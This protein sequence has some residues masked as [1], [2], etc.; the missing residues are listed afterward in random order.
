[1]K[2]YKYICLSLIVVLLASCADFFEPSSP[3][4]IDKKDVFSNPVR[5][6][7][8]IEAIYN[9]F[10]ENNSY[11]NRLACGYQGLNTDIERST[12]DKDFTL[13]CMTPSSADLTDSEGKD[14]WSYI[15]AMVERSNNVIEGVLQYGD[16]TNELM[17]YYLGEAL[18]LR[19]F[20]Y[21]ELTKYWGDVPVRFKSF[22]ADPAGAAQPKGDR[23]D[24]YEHL[25]GDLLEAA[26]LLPWAENGPTVETKN[27]TTRASKALAYAL[28]ARNNL[29]YAGYA[30]RADVN[31]VRLNTPDDALRQALYEEA[32]NACAE[33][34][35]HE[36]QK[37]LPD[38]AQ[39]F[40]NLCADVE[41]YGQSEF[42][43][44]I[45]FANG[46]RGQFLNYN[47]P[48]ADKCIGVLKHNVSSKNWN[49]CQ[50]V[51]PTFVY[52][53][54]EGDARKAV[55]VHPYTW[56]SSVGTGEVSDNEENVVLMMP[57][58]PASDERL[59]QK[60]SNINTFYLGKYR[61]E[62][63]ARDRE[64]SDD[65]INYPIVRYADVVLMFC[66]A[67]IGGITHTSVT[68]S[69][70]IDPQEQFNKIRTRAGLGNKELTMENLMK[71]RAFEFCG[72]YIRK[73]DLMRWGKLTENLIA[74]NRR[75]EELDTHT[76]EFEQTSD[77]IYF[78]FKLKDD[79]LASG[80]DVK[81]AYEMTD[82]WGLRKGE[83]GRPANFDKAEGWIA[84]SIF[85]SDDKR[86]IGANANYLLY[87]DE[88]IL[89]LR[90]YYP[91][92]L[93]N[94]GTSNGALWNDYNY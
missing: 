92:F 78:R 45:P 70:G 10:G 59:W 8:A 89:P 52:E 93:N 66:E 76:G 24:I 15:N 9:L 65:G 3:S 51:V 60:L 4:S 49:S 23:N 85:V 90:H 64:G 6:G 77:S 7:N 14:I 38:F 56:V 31:A 69:T 2:N 18:V 57:D 21:L 29:T 41:E 35:K 44:E 43:W 22:G 16:T 39:V 67:A 30:L 73:Y 79:V 48:K 83:V 62:W 11:R 1:M 80:T 20:A 55:T 5:T 12:K 26:R 42:I 94:V 13:Y 40:K 91:I 75:L 82:I 84:K 74:T 88:Q 28:L 63:M 19:S 33:V 36:P 81:F 25:R 27:K 61:V 71:E 53:F 68:N 72:E 58:L 46:T 47:A 50:T 87:Q 32:M 54:E 17:R 37:L 34:I 86:V